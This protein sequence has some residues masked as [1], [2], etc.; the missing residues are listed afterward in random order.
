MMLFTVSQLKRFANIFDNAGQVF[1]GS[2]VLSPVITPNNSTSFTQ[3]I[4]SGGI[5]TVFVWW[6]SLRLERMSS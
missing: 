6:L 5:L 4:L 3:V 1:L 2:L